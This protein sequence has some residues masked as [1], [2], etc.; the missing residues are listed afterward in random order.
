MVTR[1]VDL[2]H[3]NSCKNRSL[4]RNSTDSKNILLDLMSLY[5]LIE[6]QKIEYEGQHFSLEDV[7]SKPDGKAGNCEVCSSFKSCLNNT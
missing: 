3:E 5:E 4:V 6:S 1:N 2:E 7:C